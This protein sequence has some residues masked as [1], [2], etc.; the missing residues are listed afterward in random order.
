MTMSPSTPLLPVLGHQQHVARFTDPT[1]LNTLPLQH[2]IA[3]K[4]QACDA[5]KASFRL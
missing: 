5:F 3:A 2:K 1:Y 4:N